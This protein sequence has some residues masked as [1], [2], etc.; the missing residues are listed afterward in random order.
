MGADWL[1]QDETEREDVVT[2][3]EPMKKGREEEVLEK[4]EANDRMKCF[5]QSHCQNDHFSSRIQQYH[6]NAGRRE[7]E[8]ESHSL[9]LK[10][11]MT[12]TRW[13]RRA[14]RR[15]KGEERM[16]AEEEREM[17]KMNNKEWR[18]NEW[19]TSHVTR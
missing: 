11:K 18:K 9:S 17:R 14:K 2:V 15:M 3:C 13:K 1:R 4:R 7:E 6:Q 5:G 10:M 16:Y 8:R 12:K 19:M